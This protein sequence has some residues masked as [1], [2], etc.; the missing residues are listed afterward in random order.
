MN[1]SYIHV[2]VY[3]HYERDR[4]LKIIVRHYLQMQYIKLLLK[5]SVFMT[6]VWG[7]IFKKKQLSMVV[8]WLLTLVIQNSAAI[9]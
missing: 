3:T 4:K 7:F 9:W 8:R 2:T 6:K 5:C 1:N